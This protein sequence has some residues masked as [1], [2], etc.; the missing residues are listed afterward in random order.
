MRS[1]VYEVR[2]VWSDQHHE[3]CAYFGGNCR[4]GVVYD[5]TGFRASI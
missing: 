1:R 3:D 5:N 2:G 4:P